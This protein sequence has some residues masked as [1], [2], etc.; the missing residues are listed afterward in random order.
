[1]PTRW[2]V[3]L[4]VMLAIAGRAAAQGRVGGVVFDSLDHAK[5][6]NAEV[7]LDPASFEG[8]PRSTR[9]DAQ[10]AFLFTGVA[11]GEYTLSFTSERLDSLGVAAPARSVD[12]AA[13]GVLDVRLAMPSSTTIAALVC[14]ANVAGTEALVAGVV[15][16][17]ESGARA[18]GARVT[19]TWGAANG[20]RTA[21]TVTDADGTYRLCGVPNAELVTIDAVVA[22]ADGGAIVPRAHVALLPH[23][24]ALVIRPLHLRSDVPTLSPVRVTATRDWYLDA[25]GFERRRAQ[26]VGHFITREELDRRPLATLSSIATRIPGVKVERRLPRGVFLLGRDGCW[27]DLYIDGVY[28]DQKA[29]PIDDLVELSSVGAI[30]VHQ[31]ATLPIQFTHSQNLCGA[32]LVWTRAR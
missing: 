23:L 22:P 16:Y 29:V 31:V 19:A 24:G 11:P 21:S 25:T 15:R 26:G 20:R 2:P 1:M 10:G 5:L 12:V 13:D 30:E 7:A 6:A 14:P 17:A 18:A 3:S 28:M 4:G 9:T 32:I 27:L 8:A